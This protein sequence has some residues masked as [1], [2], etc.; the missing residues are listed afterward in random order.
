MHS[1][2]QHYA[3]FLQGF[4]YNIKYKNT[5]LNSNADGLSRLPIKSEATQDGDA[6][7]EFEINTIEALPVTFQNL[8]AETAQDTELQELLQ[9]LQ[10]GMELK[11]K[12]RFNVP[13]TEFSCQ[14][15]VLLHDNRVVVPLKLRGQVLREL[16][17][18]HPGIVKIKSIARRYCWWPG[19]NHDL[20]TIIRECAN[21][22]VVRNDPKTVTETTW[23]GTERPFQRVHVDFAGP[24]RGYYFFVLVD[25]FSKWPEVHVTKDLTSD[26]V[27]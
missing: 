22:N 15:G 19:I 3:L 6:I 12:F 21:C 25:A 23:E 17:S 18:E 16:H 27:I 9:G 5:K 26:T 20:E 2:M 11:A 24:F 4:Q 14:K 13:Q 8:V 7:D 1:A 10:K